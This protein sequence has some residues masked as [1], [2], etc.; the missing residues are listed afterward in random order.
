MKKIQ[1]FEN[2]Y[3]MLSNWSAH[4]IDIY[5]NRFTTADHAYHY[6]KFVD[7]NPEIA[8]Q[9]LNAKS[10]NIAKDITN[11]NKDLA[12]KFNDKEKIEIFYQI[13]KAKFLQHDDVKRALIK[14]KDLEIEENSPF[15][16]FWGTGDD[17]KGR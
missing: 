1:F 5:G 6:K 12:K 15:D 13:N 14:S 16:S 10:P 8:Q 3:Y 7:S 4:A 2:E 9:I 17:G 11:D